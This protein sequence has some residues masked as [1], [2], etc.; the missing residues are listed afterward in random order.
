MNRYCVFLYFY[1]LLQEKINKEAM[2]IWDHFIHSAWCNSLPAQ[3]THLT[4]KYDDM[5]AAP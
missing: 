3:P 1:S 2:I 5:S 4:P